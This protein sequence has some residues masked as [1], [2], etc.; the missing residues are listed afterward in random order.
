ML[1][2]FWCD[3]RGFLFLGLWLVGCS[4]A[5]AGIAQPK[6]DPAAAAQRAFTEYDANGDKK[7]SK[8]E[9]K[10]CWGLLSAFDRCDQDGDGSISTDELTSTLQEIQKQGAA[11]VAISCVVKHN[12]QPLEGA[13]V[14][15]VP[16][17]FLGAA[18]KPATGITALD[19]ATTPSIAD[20]ELPTEYRGR[21]RGVHCGIYRVVVTHP[22]VVIPAKYNTKSEL[23]RIVTRRDHD[24]L[25]INF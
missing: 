10:A 8:E 7:L 24:T 15:F 4:G 16:E 1:N 20:D 13:T 2:G 21:L 17:E 18:I 19:G 12:D 6:L 5:P 25:T 3:G 22:K 23:G 14:T 11:I 9:L